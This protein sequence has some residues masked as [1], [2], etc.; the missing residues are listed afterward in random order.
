MLKLT[1]K[2]ADTLKAIERFIAQNGYS[3]SVRQL[4]QKLGLSSSSTV[5]NRIEA[6]CQMGYLEKDPYSPRTL[7]VLCGS[8]GKVVQG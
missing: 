5:Q 7:R 6:L 2:R 3:P 4:G 8:D 1:K